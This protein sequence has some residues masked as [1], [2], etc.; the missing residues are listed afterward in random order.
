MT[1]VDI[2]PRRSVGRYDALFSGLYAKPAAVS[3]EI[4]A[5]FA[6]IMS[7]LPYPLDQEVELAKVMFVHGWQVGNAARIK[8]GLG[9]P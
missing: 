6:A 8:G 7:R 5:E 1:R 2:E 4:D 3:E 9:R